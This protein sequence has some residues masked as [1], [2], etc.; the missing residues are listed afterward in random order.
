VRVDAR[1]AIV[2]QRVSAGETG[3]WENLFLTLFEKKTFIEIYRMV[4]PIL[5]G[6]G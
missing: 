5:S 6:Y 2:E 1:C 3:G 4:V